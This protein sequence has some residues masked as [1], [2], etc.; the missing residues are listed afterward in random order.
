MPVQGEVDLDDMV[1]DENAGTWSWVCRCGGQYIV[2]E[3]D[4]EADC[5]YYGCNSCTLCIRVL[6][7]AA[8]ESDA[9]AD[10]DGGADADR[11][12]DTNVVDGQG[13]GE[14]VGG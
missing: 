5:E 14:D 3:H 10:A 12:A 11:G 8:E 2:S 7:E 13:V 4:L 9:D 1:E 6:Y